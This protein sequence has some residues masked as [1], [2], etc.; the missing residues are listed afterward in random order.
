MIWSG[1]VATVLDINTS[2]PDNMVTDSYNVNITDSKFVVLHM[3]SILK[4]GEYEISLINQEGVVKQ[5]ISFP[6]SEGATI[7]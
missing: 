5:D 4:I 2:N 3:E 6:K 7:G 1:C